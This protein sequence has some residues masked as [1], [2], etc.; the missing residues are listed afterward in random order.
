[1]IESPKSFKCQLQNAVATV[2]LARPERLNAL[3]FEVYRE[4]TGWFSDVRHERGIR[5]IVLRGEGESFCSGGDVRDI[6]GPLI[7]RDM[8]ETL[9]F[10]RMT[11][12]L[13]ANMIKCAKPVVAELKGVVAGAGAVI[14][15][16]ADIRIASEDCR[17][18]FLFTKVGLAGCDMG[19]AYLLPRVIGLGHALEALYCGDFIDAAEAH[20]IG[21]VNRVV[22]RSE[23]E[24][25]A[26]TLAT[27]LSEMP[28]L[29]IAMTK[30]V[31]FKELHMDLDAAIEAEAQAQAICMKHPDFDEGYQAFLNRRPPKFNRT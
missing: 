5:A 7:Q 6:I 23:L 30:E 2:T 22:P 10:T 28:A 16:A 3:T 25:R 13:V 29:G 21:L 20:R 8:R 4:L 11:G 9:E 31:L 15:L 14:A 24:N 17:F 26:F 18:A 12:R 27:Q 19:A 1:M